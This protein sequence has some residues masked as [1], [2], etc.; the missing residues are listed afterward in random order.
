[1]ETETLAQ[2]IKNVTPG[3]RI[4]LRGEDVLVTNKERTII[5]AEGISE[6]VY[7]QNIKFDLHRT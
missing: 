1:M 6:L 7:G 2:T 4:R 5:D 3:I